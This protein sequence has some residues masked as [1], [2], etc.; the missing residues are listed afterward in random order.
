MCYHA[1]VRWLQKNGLKPEKAGCVE[2][3]NVRDFLQWTLRQPWMVLHEMSH[4][5]HQN[6]IPDG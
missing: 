2:I 3:A 1:D 5:Y 6:F 4:G